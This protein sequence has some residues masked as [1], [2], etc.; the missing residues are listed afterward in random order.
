MIISFCPTI[1]L[2]ITKIYLSTQLLQFIFNFFLNRA[3]ERRH[4]QF[5]NS[6]TNLL[7]GLEKRIY[8][9]PNLRRKISKF[10]NYLFLEFCFQICLFFEYYY[11]SKIT[12]QEA[13]I[14]ACKM[15]IIL[16]WLI[17]LCWINFSHGIPLLSSQLWVLYLLIIIYD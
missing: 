12:L 6:S 14:Y 7:I 3:P 13:I 9:L 16:S 4:L 5:I 17:L 2:H 11:Y 1:Y 15:M 8:V 10:V